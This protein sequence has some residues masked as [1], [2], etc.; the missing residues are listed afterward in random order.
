MGGRIYVSLH[1]NKWNVDFDVKFY[2]INV[3]S[4][5]NELNLQNTAVNSED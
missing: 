5:F 1:E 2:N 4:E 3:N